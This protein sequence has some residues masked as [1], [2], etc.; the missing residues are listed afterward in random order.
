MRFD[1][2][3]LLVLGFI[4]LV[5]IAYL[6]TDHAGATERGAGATPVSADPAEGRAKGSH[7][8]KG[9]EWALEGRP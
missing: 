6:V 1:R 2:P 9:A 8:P 4:A 5:A 7:Q 3:L